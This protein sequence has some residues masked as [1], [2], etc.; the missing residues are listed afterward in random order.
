MP[1]HWNNN[2]Q[3]GDAIITFSRKDIFRIKSAVEKATKFK[4]AVIYGNLPPETRADQANL[5]NDPDGQ[6]EILVA[7]DAIGMGLNLN[8][9][10]ILFATIEKFNGLELA[11]LSSS[12]IKQIGGRAGRFGTQF[13]DGTVSAFNP[14]DLKKIIA[15]FK[16]PVKQIGKFERIPLTLG[17]AGVA[18]SQIQILKLSEI[19]GTSDLS[20]IFRK[21]Q[22]LTQL[23]SDFFICDLDQQIASAD[24]IASIDLTMGDRFTLVNA[25]SNYKIRPL[26]QAFLAMVESYSLKAPITISNLLKGSPLVPA[27]NSYELNSLEIAHKILVLYQYLAQRFP[28]FEDE[29]ECVSLKAECEFLI[30][31]CLHRLGDT[32]RRGPIAEGAKNLLIMDNSDDDY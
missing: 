6:L 5:F 14:N 21:F 28:F 2:I 15:A 23:T 27:N 18:P 22:E 17:K 1:L 19:L 12:Q 3:K 30:D 7:S 24:M 29:D 26:S 16:M 25:P 13:E 31:D 9:K 11:Q 20:V 4:A 8:I 32:A 10:R